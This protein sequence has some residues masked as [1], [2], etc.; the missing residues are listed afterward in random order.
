MT[1]DL[2]CQCQ[3]ILTQ[4]AECQIYVAP[5]SIVGN[6]VSITNINYIH[7][8]AIAAAAAVLRSISSELMYTSPQIRSN[9]LAAFNSCSFSIVDASC[10]FMAFKLHS[11]VWRNG[12]ISSKW[13]VTVSRMN[14]SGWSVSCA[15]VQNPNDIAHIDT[16]PSVRVKSTT[17]TCPFYIYSR[18]RKYKWPLAI[19]W[20]RASNTKAHDKS[21]C[22]FIHS[23]IICRKI[24]A[25]CAWIAGLWLAAIHI[26]G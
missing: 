17:K 23:F 15:I 22:R 9:L 24:H 7:E 13:T 11:K 10:W 6:K 5:N 8:T 3:C 1:Y 25:L 2:L 16:G 12:R 21:G 20:A 18:L 14:E 4:L 26:N 19:N